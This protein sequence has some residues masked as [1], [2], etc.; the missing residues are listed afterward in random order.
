MTQILFIVLALTALNHFI[1]GNYDYDTVAVRKTLS[2]GWFS[3]DPKFQMIHCLD[4]YLAQPCKGIFAKWS[5]IN[6]KTHKRFRI[7]FWT[8]LS[9]EIDQK[10]AELKL[11]DNNKL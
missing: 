3:E 5:Y 8:E 9:R 2:D 10:Y 11:L 6:T 1:F 4:G 7:P